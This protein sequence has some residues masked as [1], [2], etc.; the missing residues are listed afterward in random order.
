MTSQI[1]EATKEFFDVSFRWRTHESL[2][3]AY[4]GSDQ[5]IVNHNLQDLYRTHC[6]FRIAHH[7]FLILYYANVI[8]IQ[9]QMPQTLLHENDKGQMQNEQ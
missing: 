7:K 6:E 3:F 1:F 8:V 4:C 2:S 9:W 5:L